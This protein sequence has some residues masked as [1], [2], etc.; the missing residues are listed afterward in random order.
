MMARETSR[1]PLEAL[2]ALRADDTDM[3]LTEGAT[4]AL[5]HGEQ[6]APT[7]GE[8]PSIVETGKRHSEHISENS[9]ADQWVC[10]DLKMFE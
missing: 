3:Q 4:R 9:V 2:A 1:S 5:R 6:R 10:T 7:N 8:L